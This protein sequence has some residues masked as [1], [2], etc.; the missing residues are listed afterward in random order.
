MAGTCHPG[1][2]AGRFAGGI[3]LSTCGH[4]IEVGFQVGKPLFR[5]R[6][7]GCRCCG[8]GSGCGGGRSSSWFRG[9]GLGV[10]LVSTQGQNETTDRPSNDGGETFDHIDIRFD[11]IG[12]KLLQIDWL[13]PKTELLKK[14]TKRWWVHKRGCAWAFAGIESQT[15]SARPAGSQG[16]GILKIRRAMSQA[17]A[18]R[19][20]TADGEIITGQPDGAQVLWCFLLTALIFEDSEVFAGQ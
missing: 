1:N 19:Q 15:K 18:A 14:L 9:G 4:V 2:F 16:Q 20:E 13:N 7:R 8:S 6:C 11:K 17:C 10:R 3:C 12:F 5:G